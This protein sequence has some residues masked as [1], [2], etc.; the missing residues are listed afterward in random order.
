MKPRDARRF[1]TSVGFAPLDPRIARTLGILATAPWWTTSRPAFSIGRLA[2][3]FLTPPS[4]F[5]ADAREAWGLATLPDSLVIL[6]DTP[7]HIQRQDERSANLSTWRDY[8][9]PHQITT[10]ALTKKGRRIATTL[11]L[12]V[13]AALEEAA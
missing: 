5:E 13:I 9:N 2:R 4:R 3:V 6:Y 10:V 12:D 1:L 8:C 7:E 11:Q